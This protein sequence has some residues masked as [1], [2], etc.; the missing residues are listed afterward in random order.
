MATE[1]KTREDLSLEQMYPILQRVLLNAPEVE[2]AW[3]ERRMPP[4]FRTR[5]GITI[6]HRWP[7]DPASFL[8]Y[9][10][11]LLNCYTSNC[12]YSPK[13][14]DTIVDC[15]A[16]IGMFALY[17]TTLEPK[18]HIHCFEPSEST[19]SQLRLNIEANRLQNV[20]SAHQ[21]AVWKD[22]SQQVLQPGPSSGRRSFFPQSY[23][24]VLGTGEI[25]ECTTLAGVCDLCRGTDVEFLKI[26]TE[27]AEL[28]IVE[29]ADS[30][31][32]SK[33]KRVAIEFH[34]ELR[35]GTRDRLLKHLELS[36]F[37]Q[38]CIITQKNLS[39]AIGII[40]ASRSIK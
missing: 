39:Y 5:R 6:Y 30:R 16:N 35:P 14:G 38:T 18:L 40:Q 24:H 20:V 29:S 33:I 28:E 27:G 34:E 17:L 26:D 11:F 21:M 19:F 12:F 4:A 3:K 32:L 22:N 8:F 9:E 2:S 7:M 37:D 36:G 13:P 23:E 25:V 10:I 31:T 15:G 1:Q